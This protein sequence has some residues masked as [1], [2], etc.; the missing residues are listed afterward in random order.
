MTTRAQQAAE[1][2]AEK[3][4]GECVFMDDDYEG[5]YI[6]FVAGAMWLFAYINE[7][8]PV[9]ATVEDERQFIRDVIYKEIVE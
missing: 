8:I 2:F 9:P 1:E 4:F 3:R 6:S 5:T 7:T